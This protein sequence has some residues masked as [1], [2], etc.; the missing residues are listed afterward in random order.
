LWEFESTDLVGGP[1]D[2][3]HRHA[4]SRQL[5]MEEDA[6]IIANYSNP[7]FVLGG[8]DPTKSE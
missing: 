6:E 7:A 2:T 3:S 5:T 4:V 1:I 8:W